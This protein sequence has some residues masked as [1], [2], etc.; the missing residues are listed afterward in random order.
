MMMWPRG[1]DDD[2]RSYGTTWRWRDDSHHDRNTTR[3]DDRGRDTMRGLT[4]AITTTRSDCDYNTTLRDDSDRELASKGLFKRAQKSSLSRHSALS[5]AASTPTRSVS[6]GASLARVR[7]RTGSI[8]VIAAVPR[9]C[10]CICPIQ[11]LLQR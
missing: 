5:C 3:R 2:E 1:R 11:G 9:A 6:R 7:S 10:T 4:A 8:A